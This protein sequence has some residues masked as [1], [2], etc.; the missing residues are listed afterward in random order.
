MTLKEFVATVPNFSALPHPEKIVH[1][2]WY[3]QTQEG[4]QSFDQAAIRQCY[5]TFDMREPNFS[6]EFKRLAAKTILLRKGE[7]YRLEHKTRE[8]LTEIYGHHETTI[9]LSQLLRDLPGKLSDDAERF[10]LS[11]AIKCYHARAFR[12]AIVMVWNLTYDHLLHWILAEPARLSAF[13]A[14]IAGRVGAKKAATINVTR[15]EDFEDLKESET[16]DICSNAGLF[17]SKNTKQIL[18]MQLTKRNMSAHPSL[19]II[20]APE[21]ED[22]ISSLINN[23]VL[24]LK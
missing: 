18:D 19:V 21:A 16:L 20:G 2:A 4:K 1:F 12:A 17:V 13:Q 14:S 5:K 11:E 7:K 10:F 3:L 8:K 23:V 6:E 22:T 24:V 9:A 15:R